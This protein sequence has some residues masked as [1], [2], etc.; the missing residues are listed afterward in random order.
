MINII[1]TLKDKQSRHD[2]ITHITATPRGRLS[3]FWYKLTKR[4]GGIEGFVTVKIRRAKRDKKTGE[5][6]KDQNGEYIYERDWLTVEDNKHNLL[7]TA[8]RDWVHEQVL[9]NATAG[10][11][12]QGAHEI[13]VTVDATGADATDN[14]LPGEI[15]TGGLAKKDPTAAPAGSITHTASSNTTVIV[16]IWTAS[17]GHTSVQMAGLFYNPTGATGQLIFENVFT[18]TTLASGDSIELTWT[19]TIG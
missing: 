14:A 9:T 1:E 5:P 4:T 10:V 6:I 11:A 8:G 19:I 13:A 18:P 16:A 17:A 3:N 2:Y 7:T 12:E 15:T